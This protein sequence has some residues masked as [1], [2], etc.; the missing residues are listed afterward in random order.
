MPTFAK[1]STPK[2]FLNKGEDCAQC[3]WTTCDFVAPTV[4]AGSQVL[5]VGEAPGFW[6]ARDGAYFVGESGGV[7][8]EI[9]RDVGFTRKQLSVSNAVKCYDEGKATPEIVERC[10][11]AFL[12]REIAYLAA[13]GLKLIIALGEPALRA[14]TGLPGITKNRGKVLP[15]PDNPAISVLPT[16]NPAFI[17]YRPGIQPTVVSDFLLAKLV[18]EDKPNL[19]EV[20][21]ETLYTLDQVEAFFRRIWRGRD[22]V[23]D[24]ETTGLSWETDV[25]RCIGVNYGR[26]NADNAVIA[27]STCRQ[28]STEGAFRGL[29]RDW[30]ESG[31]HRFIG[32]NRKFDTHFLL[33]WC[34]VEERRMD[35]DGTIIV[36]YLF[37]EDTTKGLKTLEALA[38]IYCAMEVNYKEKFLGDRLKL[39]LKKQADF[40]QVVSDE[41][42]WLSCAADCWV[43]RRVRDAL[44]DRLERNAD[45]MHLYRTHYLP[46]QRAII[47]A[48]RVGFYIDRRRAETVNHEF[49]RGASETGQR[50]AVRAAWWYAIW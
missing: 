1:T 40:W 37:N 9:L 17:L 41:V 48:E 19:V 10:R 14:V 20:T 47:E 34:G 24:L 30:L 11:A 50:P 12:T 22:V 36:A 4:R 32:Q 38:T 42:L 39:K 13:R 29:V 31:R 46:L 8:D 43:T 23:V 28:D 16:F 45:L 27:V 2:P 44:M 25:I 49:L 3:P 6:E 26:G 15:Y 18:I 7:L 35:W 5:L 33:Q 21:H